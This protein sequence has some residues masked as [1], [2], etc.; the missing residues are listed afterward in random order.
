M[1]ELAKQLYNYE[2]TSL[3]KLVMPYVMDEDGEEYLDIDHVDVQEWI[4][5]RLDYLADIRHHGLENY[6]ATF[7]I[8]DED[9]YWKA[10]LDFEESRLIKH[11]TCYGDTLGEALAKCLVHI[12]VKVQHNS[13]GEYE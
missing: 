2:P 4:A 13:I 6:E 9:R 1:K 7:Q 8:Y 10:E 12:A 11:V 5:A 3:N